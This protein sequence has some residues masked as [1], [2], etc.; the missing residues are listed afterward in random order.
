M[1][2]TDKTTEAAAETLAFRMPDPDKRLRGVRLQQDVRLPGELLGFTRD[3]DHWVLSVPRPDVDRMEYSF[4]LQIKGGGSEWVCDPLNPLRVGGAFGDKSVLELPDY[5]APK[6]LQAEPARGPRREIALPSRGL[7]QDVP[8]LLWSAH[9]SDDAAEL[10][11]LVV[12]DGPEYDALSSLTLFLD[13]MVDDG[14]LP[15]MRAALLAPVD[16]NESYAAST[17]YSR[18]LALG[19]VPALH[20][21]APTSVTLG[22]G[23]SLGGLAMLHCQRAHPGTFAGLY[24]QS[25]SFFHRVLDDQES[26]FERFQRITS[27][28]DSVLRSGPAVDPVPIVLTCGLI[29]ENVENNRLMTR[30]LAAQGYDTRLVENRDVHTYTGWRDTFDPNLVDLVQRVLDGPGQH[31]T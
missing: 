18:A 27:F 2:R 14:R 5:A 19:L 6:W 4:E 16:R 13:A 29:E 20:K 11:L 12:H 22:M 31:E 9:G 17:S 21:L 24:L 30:S 15:A 7:P 28:V 26:S 23:A 8:A 25:S 10:P 1:E 3:G